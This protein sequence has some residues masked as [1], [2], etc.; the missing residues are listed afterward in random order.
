MSV[1][2]TPLVRYLAIRMGCID[3]PGQRKVHAEP[4]PRLGGVAFALAM[5]AVTLIVL[6]AL[7]CGGVNRGIVSYLV[8]AFL[9]VMLGAADDAR[10]LGWKVK[11]AGMLVVISLVV[12][13]GDVAI[14]QI[15]T[16]G[17]LG[18]INLGLWGIPFTYLCVIGVT[19]A[20]NLI[21]GLNGLA[22]GTSLVALVFMGVAAYLS[23]DPTLA[24][25][26]LGLAGSVGGFLIYNFPR[27]RIFMGDSGSLLLGFSCSVFAIL[28]TQ[29]A[30]GAGGG[31]GMGVPA[32]VGGGMPG[33]P[34]V[35]PM[36][37]VLV[38]ILPI[39]DTVRVMVIRMVNRRS[40]FA[41]DKTHFH[42][43]M[44]RRGLSP[45]A[46]VYVMVAIT[47]VMGGLALLMLNRQTSVP[48]LVVTL[49]ACLVLSLVAESLGKRSRRARRNNGG[50]GK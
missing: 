40:P 32:A 19:N 23:G 27:G 21:D 45:V 41:A 33:F 36:F 28:L 48:Y 1:F 50:N 25:L 5:A 49:I 13:G 39:F 6:V 22:G 15:G 42:H 7:A 30:R 16:Y 14:R 4:T 18:R 44:V 43:L 26:C 24:C 46:T 8:G 10:R 3:Q 38:L 47:A 20:I 35:D 11:L 12:F 2:S 31:P 37:P 9:L 34:A 17:T 29:G